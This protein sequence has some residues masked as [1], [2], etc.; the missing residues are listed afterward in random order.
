MVFISQPYESVTVDKFWPENIAKHSRLVYLPYFTAQSVRGDARKQSLFQMPVLLY[1]WRIIT[2]SE[3]M[4]KWYGR[5]SGKMVTDKV[6][7]TG[8]PKW[9]YSVGL[10]DVQVPQ[11]WKEKLNGKSV[12]LWN[13]HYNL[14]NT[15]TD[16]LNFAEKVI[17]YMETQ[18]SLALIWR[19]HPL[20][21]T[22]VKVYFNGQYYGKWLELLERVNK[23]SNIIYD[24][25]E[26]YDTAFSCSDA[27]ISDLSSL[28]TQYL[29]T[30]KP[31][32][33]HINQ[34]IQ[35][36]KTDLA[37]PE[38]NVVDL[39]VLPIANDLQGYKEFMHEISQGKDTMRNS[40]MELLKRDFSNAD[41]KIGERICEMLMEELI[42]EEAGK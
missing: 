33:L 1:S 25:T 8:L 34:E 24:N 38:N 15:S 39:S 14:G 12:F 7:V 29:L 41:G 10:K 37:D 11:A 22:I 28:V 32:L 17:D 20:T 19:P 30:Q 2:Q 13:T 3:E 26:S 21:E 36:A 31:I 4:L 40:R 16:I 6:R 27:L 5:I 35:T 42:D 18:P 9:D 23:S